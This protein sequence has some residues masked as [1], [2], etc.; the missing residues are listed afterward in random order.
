LLPNLCNCDSDLQ[1]I[2]CHMKHII[3]RLCCAKS[4][5]RWYCWLVNRYVV[6]KCLTE[7]WNK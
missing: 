6:D 1:A 3:I 2:S 7:K 5:E 4:M